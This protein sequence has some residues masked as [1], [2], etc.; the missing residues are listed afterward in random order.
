MMISPEEIVMRKLRFTEPQNISVLKS[1]EAGGLVKDVC[2]EASF[3][4]ASDYKWK[5]KYGGM[6]VDNIKKSKIWKT[7]T[8]GS[9]RCLPT[10]T[11]NA[12]R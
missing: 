11:W 4:Q 9:N 3:S 10:S 1:V 7:R 8:G 12:G 6:E 2:C 5:T